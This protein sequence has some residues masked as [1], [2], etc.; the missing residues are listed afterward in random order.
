MTKRVS[1]VIARESR[2]DGSA[3]RWKVMRKR[4]LV[5]FGLAVGLVV[6]AV[7][8]AP[9]SI[10]AEKQ[11][12]QKIFWGSADSFENPAEVDYQ[13]VVKATPEYKSIRKEKVESGTAKYWILISKA[14][15][16]AVRVINEVG[17][18]NGHD[19]VAAQGYLGGLE[20]PIAAANITGLA[21]KK[22]DDE[23]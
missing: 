20:P 19:L 21:L 14:S 15:D 2:G 12:E 22:L 8:A 13:K 17:I 5:V 16:R 23:A 6:S 18:E 1:V 11:D 10:P 7:W 3:Q 9:H 4:L